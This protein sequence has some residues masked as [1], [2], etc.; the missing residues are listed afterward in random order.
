MMRVLV[1]RPKDEAAALCEPLEARGIEVLAEP[2]LS[3]VWLPPPVD[4]VSGDPSAWQAVVVTSQN[5]LR[6]L[7]RQPGWLARLRPMTLYAVG[8]A[9]AAVGRSIGFAE[10]VEGPGTAAGLS[11]ML[12]SRLQPARGRLIIPRA[13]DTAFDLAGA[14]RE[15]GY[16]VIAP[17]VYRMDA[18]QALRPQT[19]AALEA[20]TIDAITLL[21]NRT[22]Q[23]YARLITTHKQLENI[24]HIPHLC[25]SRSIAEHVL[26]LGAR[27]VQTALRPNIEE[28][29]ALVGGEAKPL[30]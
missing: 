9:S 6:W 28:I 26:Q 14:L 10:V 20:G 2:L 18:A 23:T 5:A 11:A 30:P 22:A 29:L 13:Q 16:D 1:T 12:Q 21:S 7:A 4:L 15:R 25:L 27:T 3:V 17:I 24:E 19:I 8:P